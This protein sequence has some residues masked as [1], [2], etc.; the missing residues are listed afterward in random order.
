MKSI[1]QNEMY[2]I[3]Q[4]LPF[5]CHIILPR[6]WCKQSAKALT[7]AG[8]RRKTISAQESQCSYI[9]RPT[10]QRQ[11][12]HYRI[13]PRLQHLE[14]QWD[15]AQLSYNQRYTVIVYCYWMLS[16]HHATVTS[17]ITYCS[18]LPELAL[19]FPFFP[20]QK[21][22]TSILS[23]WFARVVILQVTTH[24]FTTQCYAHLLRS[25]ANWVQ[26][27]LLPEMCAPHCNLRVPGSSVFKGSIASLF[28]CTWATQQ[29]AI[30]SLPLSYFCCTGMFPNN[31]PP[32]FWSMKTMAKCFSYPWCQH[33]C[34]ITGSP[35]IKHSPISTLQ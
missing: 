8:L 32:F 20:F 10:P 14:N 23:I 30:H 12:L 18:Y 6:P 19:V 17:P 5:S 7:L 28:L 16:F 31:E 22:L 2:Y 25:K 26:L 33:W 1:N 4:I 9:L 24:S 13:Q 21:I 15:I 35:E 3:L 11:Q 29:S 34:H 27:F